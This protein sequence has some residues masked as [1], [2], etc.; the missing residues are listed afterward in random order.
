M[1]PKEKK[2]FEPT[3][4]VPR[5]IVRTFE[6]FKQQLL[7]GSERAAIREYRIS[8]YQVL[9]SARCLFVLITIPIATNWFVSSWLLSPI[10]EHFW[11]TQQNEIFLNSYQE[12]RAF[13]ELESFSD[14]LFFESLLSNDS[15]NDARI[16]DT[17]NFPEHF[18]TVFA[19]SWKPPL[20]T[21]VFMDETTFSVTK[22]L[23]SK[24]NPSFNPKGPPT[25][26][27]NPPFGLTPLV[28]HEPPRGVKPKG[29]GSGSWVTNGRFPISITPK[30]GA[31]QAGE[32]LNTPSF[33]IFAFT[34]LP[35]F[36]IPRSPT[37]FTRSLNFQTLRS[38]TTLGKGV[39]HEISLEISKPFVTHEISKGNFKPF[40]YPPFGGV[41]GSGSERNFAFF[42]RSPNHQIPNV[43]LVPMERSGGKE[44]FMKSP[45]RFQSP[46]LPMKSK[47]SN[48]LVTP[49][50]GGFRVQ[51][52]KEVGNLNP[53]TPRT[54]HRGVGGNG[55]NS[56]APLGY[57]IEDFKNL[58]KQGATSFHK[59]EGVIEDF[60]PKGV[61]TFHD[62]VENAEHFIFSKSFKDGEEL[63]YSVFP[64]SM[65][66]SKQFK[67]TGNIDNLNEIVT[68][69]DS[70]KI[71]ERIQGKILE[72]AVYYNQQTI[73][74]IT[75][76]AGDFI[77]VFTLGC[78][79]IWM[80]PEISILKSF[81]IEAI[82]SLSDT[83]KS[84]LLILLTY[85]LVGFHSPRG[86]ET[87]LELLLKHFGLPENQDFV[88][89]FVATF[90]VL[91]DTVFKYW[92]FRHLN[93]ISPST[94]A[95]YHS[96]IE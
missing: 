58:R 49:P 67:E 77:S 27:S 30:G 6:R 76:I 91:L 1:E 71:K 59:S 78:L 57:E 96:M 85:L 26:F 88:F 14:K 52:Q 22:E 92:I 45:R 95:T 29:G 86:W 7:P 28:T 53:I 68:T 73:L 34:R 25:G 5:S 39:V 64:Y 50:L 24:K 82:Y 55:V 40:G 72:L 9:V 46:L 15:L 51:V 16:F 48:P 90:P 69:E 61:T 60:I 56:F 80:R 31:S 74:S 12:E 19:T 35:D 89:L 3:G 32:I 42:P 23:L 62:K 38:P 43:V 81:L 17:K 87:A 33:E 20:P 11:N 2:A 36:Q 66:S 79:F 65:E 4:L 75:N 54:P 83:T 93:K 13:A 47:I 18:S 63:Y 84:F 8:R 10:I 70:L 37:T 94:V 21:S 41:Q 44:L